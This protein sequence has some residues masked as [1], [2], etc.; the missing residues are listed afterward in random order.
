MRTQV[1]RFTLLI[2]T[3]ALS[4]T[5]TAQQAESIGDRTYELSVV[6][7]DA[8]DFHDCAIFREDHSLQLEAS[9]GLVITWLPV[10]A[11]RTGARFYAV[12]SAANP[13]GLA[14]HGAFLG[15]TGAISGNAVNDRGQTFTFT[16][17]LNPDCAIRPAGYFPRGPY[18]PLS[19]TGPYGA[20]PANPGPY[21]PTEESVAGRLY[22]MR[23]YGGDSREDCY[24]FAING[25]LARNGGANLTWRMD[26]LNTAED[27]FQAVGSPAFGTGGVAAFGQRM[28]WGEL[29]VHGFDNQEWGLRR[30][31]GSGQETSNCINE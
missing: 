1:E 21:E 31:V 30:Y 8:G 5:V 10:A 9:N 24:Q 26:D 29:R 12:T 17:T 13:Y 6:M 7:A 23:L 22:D 11:D 18:P 2:A 14:L 28:P 20:A 15:T 4:G 19:A 3:L 27:T 25:V 16:G